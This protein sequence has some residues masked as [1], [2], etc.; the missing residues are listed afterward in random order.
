MAIPNPFVFDV[1]GTLTESRSPISH[2][3]EDLLAEIV[4]R[5]STVVI[6]SGAR[7]ETLLEQ[8]PLLSVAPLWVMGQSGNDTWRNGTLAWRN[9]LAEEHVAEILAHVEALR[10]AFPLGVQDEGDLVDFRGG[11][12]SFS[13]VG[14]TQDLQTKKAFDPDGSFRRRVLAEVPFNSPGLLATVAGTTSLD[15]SRAEW[16]KRGNLERL[17]RVLGID[18]NR[19][20]YFG[21]RFG[22]GGNDEPVRSLIPTIK[23]V[24]SPLDTIEILRAMLAA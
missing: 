6:I 16:N 23:E 8:I 18:P 2:E 20:V 21:D 19:A 1:D 7:R 14:H 22:Q 24:R 4:S 9:T 10:K 13:F 12:L 15:Y 3:A 11:Q 17:F 5:G